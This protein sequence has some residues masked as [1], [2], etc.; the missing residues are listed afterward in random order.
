MLDY[1]AICGTCPDQFFDL[2]PALLAVHFRA[3]EKR[4]VQEHN[5]SAWAVWTLGRLAQTDGKHYPPL[6]K[7]QAK[8]GPARKQTPEEIKAKLVVAFG[9]G[10]VK[11][12]GQK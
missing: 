6:E 9:T 7:L 11:R 12:K 1:L 8:T 10:R 2:T 3:H 4:K 5:A